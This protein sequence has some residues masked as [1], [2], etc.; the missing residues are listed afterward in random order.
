M[1]KSSK[2]KR[3]ISVSMASLMLFAAPLSASSS[4]NTAN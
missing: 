3:I 4:G 2:L 1:K